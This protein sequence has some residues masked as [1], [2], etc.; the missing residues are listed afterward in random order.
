MVIVGKDAY[1]HVALKGAEAITP[2]ILQPGTPSKSDPLGQ[3][4]MVGWKTYHKAFIANQLWMARQRSLY[5]TVRYNWALVI[6]KRPVILTAYWMNCRYQYVCEGHCRLAAMPFFIAYPFLN[7]T[8]TP[9]FGP[10]DGAVMAKV[11]IHNL[12]DNEL[13][14]QA[15]MLGVAFQTTSQPRACAKSWRKC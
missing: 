10:R 9:P 4:G 14:D 8:L 6:F 3:K 5:S 11:N 13:R 15:L 1:G 7:Q 2:S 12:S